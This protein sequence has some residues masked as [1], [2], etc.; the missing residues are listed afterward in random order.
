MDWCKALQSGCMDPPTEMDLD[1]FDPTIGVHWPKLDDFPEY[2]MSDK[3]RKAPT[4]LQ[5]PQ[6]KDTISPEAA[7][8]GPLRRVLV[9]G[10][11]GGA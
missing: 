2:T 6:F 11:S 5:R 1:P 9:I 10:A 3:D 8:A 7:A 4:F